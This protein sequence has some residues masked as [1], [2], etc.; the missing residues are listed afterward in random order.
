MGHIKI[1][2]CLW[3]VLVGSPLLL[4]SIS[5]VQASNS[6][7]HCFTCHTNPRQLIKITREISKLNINKP[8]GSAETTGEG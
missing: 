2:V 1:K 6:E 3:L 8:G 5:G 7:N 4:Y